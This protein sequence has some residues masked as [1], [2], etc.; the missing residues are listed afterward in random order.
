MSK[1]FHSNLCRKACALGIIEYQINGF[2]RVFIPC[3]RVEV[4]LTILIIIRIV[5][6]IRTFFVG[7]RSVSAKA[8]HV[9]G[10]VEGLICLEGLIGFGH[11]V[12]VRT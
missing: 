7:T 3:S 4:R 5:F 12:I 8:V 10:D 6:S 2:N 11:N 9:D 1:I